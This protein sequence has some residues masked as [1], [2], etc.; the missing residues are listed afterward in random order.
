MLVCVRVQLTALITSFYSML[1]HNFHNVVYLLQLRSIGF[2]IEFES[3]LS[4]L[5]RFSVFL[6]QFTY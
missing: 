3:L 1:S 2:L 6:P 5:G 4:S